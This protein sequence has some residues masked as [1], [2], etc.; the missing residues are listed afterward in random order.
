M[1]ASDQALFAIQHSVIVRKEFNPAWTRIAPKPIAVDLCALSSLALVPL[2]RQR[3]SV[4]RLSDHSGP[5]S[6]CSSRATSMASSSPTART[7]SG[8]LRTTPARASSLIG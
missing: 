3:L 7:G 2:L 5:A 4:A 6:S 8:W 1:L